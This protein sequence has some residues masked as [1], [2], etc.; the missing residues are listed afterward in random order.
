MRKKRNHTAYVCK[1]LH[2]TLLVGKQV[3]PEKRTESKVLFGMRFALRNRALL[4]ISW[5]GRRMKPGSS[6]D[7][8][9]Y[10]MPWDMGRRAARG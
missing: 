9:V 5:T 6:H 8:P 2:P 10:K 1:N 3:D 4:S 7:V